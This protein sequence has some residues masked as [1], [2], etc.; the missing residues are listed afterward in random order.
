[1]KPRLSVRSDNDGF[2]NSLINC[3]CDIECS[4]YFAPL[5]GRTPLDQKSQNELV[6]RFQSAAESKFKNSFRNIE[7]TIEYSPDSER[8]DRIDIFGSGDGFV[9]VIEIDKWRADQV[10]KKFVSRNALFTSNKVYFISLCY[11]GTDNMNLTEC[12]KYFGY[13]SALALR[14]GNHYAGLTVH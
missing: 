12:K 3:I 13:C 9:V 4:K 6:A 8:R 7:W 2:L 10:A 5:L 1:M 11:P 14:I